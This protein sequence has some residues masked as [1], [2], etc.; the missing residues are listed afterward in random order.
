MSNFDKQFLER[1]KLAYEVYSKTIRP[2]LNIENFIMWLYKEYGYVHPKGKN[3][4]K[5]NV[6]NYS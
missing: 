2:D 3:Y 5:S 4:G 6:D 1:I